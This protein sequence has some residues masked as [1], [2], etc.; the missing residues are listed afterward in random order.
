MNN[1]AGAPVGRTKEVP[2]GETGAPVRQ[3]AGAASLGFRRLAADAVD[4]M[5]RH[6][7]E[8]ATSLGDHRFDDQLDD[9]SEE[10]RA[11]MAARLRAHR[12]K[13]AALAPDELGPEEQVDRAVLL[14]EL[15]R[16]EWLA[17]ELAR[18]RWD[19]LYYNPG[20]AIYPL[21]SRDVL[22]LPERL[23]AIASR[24][25]CFPARLE[26]ARRQ[27]EAPP[28]LHVETAL[29]R[30]RGTVAL[31]EQVGHLLETEPSMAPLVEPAQRRALEALDKFGAHLEHLREGPH[32]SPRLGPERF[33]RKLALELS[34][35]LDPEDV[36]GQARDWMDEVQSDL[37]EAAGR[38]L[39][40]PGD[41]CAG[42]GR[43]PASAQVGPGAVRSALEAVASDRP[44]A[45]SFLPSIEA[46]LLR[47]RET[48]ASLGVVTLPDD[49]LRVELMPPFRRGVG[50]AYCDPAGP[51]EEGGET[52]FA[53]E[54]TPENWSEEQKASFYREYNLAM[55]TNLT[56]H[57]AMPG[58]MVQ[59][60]WAR[61]FSGPTLARKIFE[62]GTFV[63]GWAVHAERIMAEAGQGG[64]AVRLQQLKMQLRVAANAI[65]DV[66]VHA[67]D[68]GEGEALALMM[69]RCYQEESEAR[70]KWRR[71]CL[72]S[73]QLSTYFV[74]YQQLS[75]L[76]ARLGQRSNYDE[77]LAHGSP[78]PALLAKLLLP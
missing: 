50:G 19:P 25:E 77:V 20:E 72:T 4:D 35:P 10:G 36:L 61:R 14:G 45:A 59:L 71:A 33:A 68:M 49:P 48:V 58:H 9:L 39:A 55:I 34:S 67:G 26:V 43:A 23:R 63:E 24:L 30:H 47:C 78:P 32:R 29:D 2:A 3:E 53:V 44:D 12:Q 60:A 17:S 75:D 64:L 62:S 16:R 21:L 18:Q 56:V 5:L 69:G 7:P 70:K 41:S 40:D 57:E 6:S 11:Q 54:P 66:S 46:A 15:E 73:A 42:R 51:L 74:G 52:S 22:A 38:Y 31:V 8:W 76:F 65:I 1:E 13:V 28:L 27:L 37:E